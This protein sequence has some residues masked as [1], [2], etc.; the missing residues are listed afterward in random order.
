M[1]EGG[2]EK[3]G[4]KELVAEGMAKQEEEDARDNNN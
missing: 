2:S 3:T 1:A 4:E